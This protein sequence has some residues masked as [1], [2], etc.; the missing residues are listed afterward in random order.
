MG[1]VL[2]SRN[3]WATASSNLREH[4]EAHT[5]QWAALGPFFL[6]AYVVAMGWSWLRVRDRAGANWF[7]VR[8]GLAKGG[9]RMPT[10]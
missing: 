5:W 6:P 9:Y 1:N 2:I 8:A 4:E 10:P 3:D 7:E